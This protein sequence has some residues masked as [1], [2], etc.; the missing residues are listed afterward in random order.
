[1][2]YMIEGDI[3]CDGCADTGDPSE[4]IGNDGGESDSPDHCTKCLIPFNN[5]LTADGIAYV[6]DALREKLAESDAMFWAKSAAYY[7]TWYAFSPHCAITH[8]WAKQLDAYGG[9]SDSDRETVDQ[10]LE[11]YDAGLSGGK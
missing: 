9:L 1:M 8:D 6:V 3:F 2:A 7:G 10:F 5:S 4:Y 11:R